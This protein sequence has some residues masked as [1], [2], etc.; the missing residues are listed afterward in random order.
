MALNK[1]LLDV[2]ACPVCKGAVEPVDDDSGL[3]CPKCD[4]VYP[5]K[6]DIP[7][8]LPDQ[9]IPEKDWQGRA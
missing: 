7:I 3:K 9:S 5:V 6:D 1:D 4:V 8:M 2:L